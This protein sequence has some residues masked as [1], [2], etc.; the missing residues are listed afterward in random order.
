[1]SLNF[2]TIK[3][4]LHNFVILFALLL[5]AFD[6]SSEDHL[7]SE[8]MGYPELDTGGGGVL[9]GEHFLFLIRPSTGVPVIVFSSVCGHSFRL[10]NSG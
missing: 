8:Y 10:E 9:V 4:L 3:I 1:M 7:I 6:Q 5:L 2:N